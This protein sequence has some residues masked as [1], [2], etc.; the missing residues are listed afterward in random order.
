MTIQNK[1]LE[2]SPVAGAVFGFWAYVSHLVRS[3]LKPPNLEGVAQSGRRLLV[4]DRFIYSCGLKRQK[5]NRNSFSSWFCK[6]SSSDP[7][8]L[9]KASFLRRGVMTWASFEALPY[10]T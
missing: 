7:Q 9:G 8:V 10:I 2:E 5:F 3:V 1:P 6:S 4:P